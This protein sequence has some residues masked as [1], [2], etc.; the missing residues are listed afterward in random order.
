ML[1]DKQK[2]RERAGTHRH[3]GAKSRF[4]QI[5]RTRL[6]F[7]RSSYPEYFPIL[8]VSDETSIFRLQNINR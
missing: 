7:L 4:S 6:E 1:T 8:S 3:D 2:E 5:L